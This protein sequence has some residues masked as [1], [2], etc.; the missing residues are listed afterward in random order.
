MLPRLLIVFAVALLWGGPLFA[1]DERVF[2]HRIQT[3]TLNA[4]ALGSDPFGEVR[5]TYSYSPISKT[6]PLLEVS[7]ECHGRRMGVPPQ[8]LSK[9][10][11]LMLE[12]ARISSE[13]GDADG[14][15]WL[16]LSFQIRGEKEKRYYIAFNHVQF[17]KTFVRP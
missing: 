13:A 16:Y 1:S 2:L 11:E 4:K 8:A 15:S 10:P 9:H 14:E 17:S 3:V 6:R 5:A 12:T 7:V